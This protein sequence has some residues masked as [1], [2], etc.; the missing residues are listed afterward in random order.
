MDLVPYL[1]TE[2]DPTHN[3]HHYLHQVLPL[4]KQSGY[5]IR[6]RGQGLTLPKRSVIYVEVLFV[7][8]FRETFVSII[9][10]L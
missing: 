10:G 1:T 5:N 7:V 4:P 6:S 8:C 2:F 3:P 9:V